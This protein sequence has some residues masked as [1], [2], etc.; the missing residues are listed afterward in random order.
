[1]KEQT[2]SPWRLRLALTVL[3]RSFPIFA[4]TVAIRLAL[5]ALY[6]GY[7]SPST[8]ICLA[9][10]LVV[11]EWPLPALNVWALAM[12]AAEGTDSYRRHM[13]AGRLFLVAFLVWFLLVFDD[14]PAFGF[15]VR[16][17]L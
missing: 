4:A 8:I 14:G 9:S 16:W 1:M 15:P 17:A 3:K 12:L 13:W 11:I 5:R 2:I 6:G 10:V 7:M